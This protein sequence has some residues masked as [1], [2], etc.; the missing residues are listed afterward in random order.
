MARAFGHD[1]LI[2]AEHIALQHLAAGRIKT[3]TVNC[4]LKPN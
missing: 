3:I 4:S 1:S 2:H